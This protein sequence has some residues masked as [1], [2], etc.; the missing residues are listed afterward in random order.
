M[1]NSKCSITPEQ[2]RRLF[3][4]LLHD[5]ADPAAERHLDD[6]SIVAAAMG[7]PL[8]ET[9]TAHLAT[10]EV[11]ASERDELAHANRV[12]SSDIGGERVARL[13]RLAVSV[14]PQES[15]H[16]GAHGK[17]VAL[18]AQTARP[19][20][21][22]EDDQRKTATL[23]AEGIVAELWL[24]SNGDLVCFASTHDV[25]LTTA[26][27][28]LHVGS[29][30]WDLTLRVLDPG[31]LVGELHIPRAARPPELEPLWLEVLHRS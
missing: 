1:S 25:I 30:C 15:R 7:E 22:A 17:A 28:R 2:T 27:C 3:S 20:S 11:C 31:R 10:C 9:D 5:A 21:A 14:A 26:Y 18:A 24:D 4:D 12:W 16:S 29:A 6:E 23:E 8:E 19:D 13:A